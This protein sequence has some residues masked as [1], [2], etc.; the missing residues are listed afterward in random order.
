[1]RYSIFSILSFSLLLTD[2]ACVSQ[3]DLDSSPKDGASVDTASIFADADSLTCSD[4]HLA[5][6]AALDDSVENTCV[7]D[8]DCIVV[9]VDLECPESDVEMHHCPAVTLSTVDE[10]ISNRNAL[11][12]ELCAHRTEPCIGTGECVML[13]EAYCDAGSCRQRSAI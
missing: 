6:F 4:L 10:F 13:F 11:G 5:W 7:V 1:M 8:G 12:A 9:K 2:L 3:P